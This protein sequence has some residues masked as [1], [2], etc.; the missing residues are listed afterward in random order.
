M[1]SWLDH[2]RFE[3]LLLERFCE[4]YWLRKDFVKATGFEFGKDFVASRLRSQI[5]RWL[6]AVIDKMFIVLCCRN[7]VWKFFIVSWGL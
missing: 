4:S 7:S 3:L 5:F 6:E 1:W 2:L